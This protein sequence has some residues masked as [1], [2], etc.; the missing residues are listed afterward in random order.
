MRIAE[1]TELLTKSFNSGIHLDSNGTD[2]ETNAWKS[3]QSSFKKNSD[4]DKKE[5]QQHIKLQ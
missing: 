1:L 5:N 4:E 3:I 2:A